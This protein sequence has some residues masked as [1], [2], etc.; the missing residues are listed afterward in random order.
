MPDRA[1]LAYIYPSL[2]IQPISQLHVLSFQLFEH[3]VL[4]IQLALKSLGDLFK[5]SDILLHITQEAFLLNF[6]VLGVF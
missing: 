6:M 4:L 3:A 1:L 2:F 5:V